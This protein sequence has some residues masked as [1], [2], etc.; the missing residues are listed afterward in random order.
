MRGVARVVEDRGDEADEPDYEG[1][2]DLGRGPGEL[3][4]CPGERDDARRRAADDDAVPAVNGVQ[5]GRVRRQSLR[6]YIQSI[7]RNAAV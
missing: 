6:T 3:D 4:A 7:A 1:G 5:K 2:E